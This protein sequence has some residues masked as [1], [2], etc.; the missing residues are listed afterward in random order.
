MKAH[1]ISTETD[2]PVSK[3]LDIKEGKMSEKFNE[4]GHKDKSWHMVPSLNKWALKS[5]DYERISLLMSVIDKTGQ[6]PQI[7]IGGKCV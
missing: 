7:E 4:Q 3:I 2:L 5:L 6:H 1:D